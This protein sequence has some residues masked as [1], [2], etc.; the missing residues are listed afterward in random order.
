MV[1]MLLRRMTV[2][3]AKSSSVVTPLTLRR[4]LHC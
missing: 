4:Q 1:G 2:V 3:I